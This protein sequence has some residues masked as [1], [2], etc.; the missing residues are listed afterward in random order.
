MSGR[1]V[2]L[3]PRV[4]VRDAEGRCLLLRRSAACGHWAGQWEI[5]GGKIDPGEAFDAALR[6]EA[7]EETGLAVTL[8]GVLGASETDVDGKL[9]VYLILSGRLEPGA[10]RLSEEHDDYRW[11]GP[12]EIAAMDLCP[13]FRS[14]AALIQNKP[15]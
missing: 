11:V 3:S 14:L 1:P 2:V 8:G 6:R 10:V 5:P 7:V 9:V 12:G 4:V 15:T 13:Q